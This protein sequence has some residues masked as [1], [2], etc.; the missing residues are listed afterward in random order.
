MESENENSENSEYLEEL[1]EVI[2]E[3]VRNQNSDDIETL[4]GLQKFLNFSNPGLIRI[5]NGGL[6]ETKRNKICRDIIHELLNNNNQR[7][8]TKSDFFNLANLIQSLFPNEIFSTYYTPFGKTST[9]KTTASGKLYNTYTN[10]RKQLFGSQVIAPRPK[11]RK[12]EDQPTT[13]KNLDVETNS[14][15]SKALLLLS[16]AVNVND[17]EVLKA[18]EITREYRFTELSGPQSTAQIFRKYPILD[19]PEGYKLVSYYCFIHNCRNVSF[20]QVKKTKIIVSNRQISTKNLSLFQW[21]ILIQLF[22]L[23]NS[24]PDSTKYSHLKYSKRV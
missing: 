14:P 3:P 5:S 10:Y 22:F 24:S 20:V 23:E 17:L 7:V 6:T 4:D 11:K 21:L 8:L 12:R 16:T 2:E 13:P 19:Q 15:L 9:S 1:I 18:W